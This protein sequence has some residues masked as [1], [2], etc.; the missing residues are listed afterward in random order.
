[1]V[2]TIFTLL[3]LILPTGAPHA[4]LITPVADRPGHDRCYA[5]DP[6]RITSELAR[7][8]RHSF[9]VGLEATVRWSVE[10]CPGV[11]VRS[12]RGAQP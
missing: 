8:P 12:P 2:D 9:E 3:D 6:S 7:Q 11:E 1:V 5:I 10:R 4:R